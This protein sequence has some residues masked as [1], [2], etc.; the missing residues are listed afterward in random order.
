MPSPDPTRQRAL[1]HLE[2]FVR[3]L[4][5]GALAR[6]AAWKGQ[7]RGWLSPWRDDLRQELAVDCLSNAELIVG[8]E[9]RERH[10]R[11]LRLIERA[12]RRLR[13]DGLRRADV[14]P[15]ALTRS[16]APP[17]EPRLPLADIANLH[18]GRI[19]LGATRRRLGRS[20]QWLQRR[21][22]E[23]VRALGWDHADEAFWTRRAAEALVGL[24]ADQLVAA[25]QVDSVRPL[26][27]PDLARRT[28]RLRRMARQ[29]P[30]RSSTWPTRRALAPWKR[31]QLA[32]APGPRAVLAR[33]V[34]LA[35]DHAA[36][37]LWTFEAHAA[38]GDH[39]AAARA[40]RQA[41]RCPDLERGAQ[42]LARARLCELR[43]RLGAGLLLLRRARRRWPF[44]AALLKAFARLL[45]SSAPR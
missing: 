17:T 20:R 11:W 8:L 34:E 12:L 28:Q 4:L 16:A 27:T 41:R 45:P 32:P 39:A 21:V 26:A 44:D 13:G 9:Q 29:F 31:R 19:N 22:D 38:A 7:P 1:A 30:V 40:L 37:W 10:R 3:R 6:I 43:G 15:D 5:P 33:A 25:G 36:A 23:T 18:N 2:T 42:A 14:D 24:A 35:P